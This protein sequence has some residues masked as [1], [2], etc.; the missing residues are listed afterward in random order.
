VDK[1]RDPSHDAESP[2]LVPES[3]PRPPAG[4]LSKDKDVGNA[5]QTPPSGV[6]SSVLHRPPDSD[7]ATLLDGTPL[8]DS[9]AATLL[10][11][12]P[13]SDAPTMAGTLAP[14]R[15]PGISPPPRVKP[16]SA[17]YTAPMLPEGTVLG[18]RYQIERPLGEGGMGAVYK[19]RDLELDRLVALKVIRPEL[20]GNPDILQRFKQEILLASQVTHRNVIRIY[21]L[22]DA[23]GIKFITM[24]FLEGEDLRSLLHQHGKLSVEES[25][26]IIE[27]TLAGLSV[28]HQQGIIHRDLKPGNIMREASGRVVVMDFGLARSLGGDGMTRSGL[29]VGTMEYMS[30][31]QAQAKEL[32]ARSDVFTVGLIWYELL[33][34]K[35]PY[36]ADSAIASLLKRTQERAIPVVEHDPT[37]PKV[38]SDIVSR[39]LERDPAMRYQNAEDMLAD[40]RAWRGHRTVSASLV[41]DRLLPKT[42]FPW[43]WVAAGLT[44]LVLV[45]G[46]WVGTRNSAAPAG[47]TQA[48]RGPVTSLAILPF[49]N[50]SGDNTWNWLGPSLGDMLSTDVGQSAHL[51]TISP[52]R[53]QQILHDLRIEPG[54]AI[55]AS[56]LRRIA[57]FSNA[58][59]V[60]SGQ[61]VRLGDQIRIDA[62]LQD[63]KHGRTAPLKAEAQNQQDISAA[64]DRL[65][66]SIRQNLALSSDLVKELR[67]QSFKPTSSSIEALRDYNEGVQLQRAGNNIE[68]LKRFQSATKTDAQ[69]ALA[70]SRL[71]E[72]YSALGYDSEAEQAAQ[73]ALDASQELPLAAKYLIQAS[74]AR[75]N[76][77]NAKAITAYQNLEKSFPDDLDVQFALGS[78]YEDAGKLDEARAHFGNVLKTDS[79]NLDA[80]LASGRV[81]IKAGNAQAGLD[82]LA[83]ARTLVIDLNNEEQQAL[84]L[85]ATGIAYK[86][87]NKPQEALRNYQ[88][89]MEINRRLGKKRGVAASLA[90]IAQVQISLGKADDGLKTYQQA[91]AL[92]REIGAKKEVGDTLIDMGALYVDR[93]QFDQGLTMF[94]ESLQIQ[95]DAGDETNQALCLNNIGNVYM[96]RG[97]NED[98]LT[99]FQQ[100]LQ[101]REKLN[102]PG[103]IAETLGNLGSTNVSLGQ[104]DQATNAYM[105]ALDLYRKSG[106][107]HGAAM[108][109][110]SLGLMFQTQGRI[111]PAISSLQDAVKGLR[112]AG[113][114]GL[115]LAQALDDLAGALARAGRGGESGKLLEEAQTIAR[116]LKSEPLN[117]ALL[118]TD[119]DMKFYR[120]ELPAARVAYEQAQRQLSRTA[121]A[122]AQLTTKLNV[123][124]VAV[125]EGRSRAAISDLR[126]LAQ[127]A[128]AMGRKSLAVQASAWMAEAML[129]DKD[130][131]GARRE[132]DRI[133]PR[134]EKLG[135]RLQS[136]K[137]RYLLGTAMRLSGSTAESA[138]QYKAALNLLNEIQKEAGAE[139]LIER[140]D[141]KAAYEEAMRWSKS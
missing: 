6:E 120:G 28:A 41:M 53:L 50:A 24:E 5:V 119:G 126:S 132:L 18:G 12:R 42:A 98:A 85:Q 87:L 117:I 124:K 89:A 66:D 40:I 20:A 60:V 52:D 102:V 57:E 90:E 68:A 22:G 46:V 125:M 61:F 73:H 55:D 100:A 63:L 131:S 58:D 45:S 9:D 84:I 21:D 101:L 32:D 30:P 72:T 71:A 43:K 97:E 80:L 13:A 121:D 33:T 27:Q 139:H 54:T 4:S 8:P 113:D 36:H 81:E 19:A 16:V 133:L 47:S 116:G 79:K 1:P 64:V 130:Y 128:D 94:K 44:G 137:I 56:T 11:V 108:E 37:I 96:A 112:D 76:K 7:A 25:E 74:H 88:D 77:D 23:D 59:I 35:M 14:N 134:S 70:F 17:T 115:P 2:T 15:H 106:D 91:L 138:T 29:M 93:G 82:P 51:R 3:R 110:Q 103:D 99:Y 114:R 38:V 26:S 136:A 127:R 104:Y 34:G 95:R 107:N 62:V 69:F 141:L 31:E 48:A 92:R 122:D 49:H 129:K 65:A 105:R 140:S 75:I 78:L 135:L 83:R 118:N 67:A 39:C 86:V 109:S 111:G 123:T 10:D